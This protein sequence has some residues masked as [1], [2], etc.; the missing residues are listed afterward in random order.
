MANYRQIARDY[1]KKVCD[2]GQP[3]EL[4]KGYYYDSDNKLKDAENMFCVFNWL[5][6][7]KLKFNNIAILQSEDE[8]DAFLSLPKEHN[9]F[10]GATK[11]NVILDNYKGYVIVK[12]LTPNYQNITNNFAKAFQL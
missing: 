1:I 4:W 12:Y 9:D 10:E 2:I 5:N 8:L 3:F 7:I 6:V 11:D